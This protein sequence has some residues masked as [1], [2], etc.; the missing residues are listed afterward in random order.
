VKW[1]TQTIRGERRK[2]ERARSRFVHKPTQQRLHDVRTTARR[3]RSLLE[4]VAD[5]AAESRLLSRIK[6]VAAVTDAARDATILL[7]LL[8]SSLDESEREAALALLDELRAR[9][10]FATR[11]AR[12]R[13]RGTSFAP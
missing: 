13:L 8:E 12:K 5:L 7:E 1:I 6:R 3:L 4:D 9:Q 2:L 11:D 10:R